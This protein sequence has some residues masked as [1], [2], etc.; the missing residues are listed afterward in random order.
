MHRIISKSNDSNLLASIES[1][2]K[3][4]EFYNPELLLRSLVSFVNTLNEELR[5]ALVFT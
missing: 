2:Q 5:K 1:F 4:Q 3:E